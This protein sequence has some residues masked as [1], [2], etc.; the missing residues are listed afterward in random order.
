MI[1]CNWQSEKWSKL[2]NR[3]SHGD[4]STNNQPET[5]PTIIDSYYNTAC[6]EV[7]ECYNITRVY[8]RCIIQP[9]RVN[10]RALYNPAHIDELTFYSIFYVGDM[11]VYNILY[12]EYMN[13]I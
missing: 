5:N 9:V 6:V 7:R 13:V 11:V 10:N 1:K 12:V 4:R 3:Q 2:I 8:G